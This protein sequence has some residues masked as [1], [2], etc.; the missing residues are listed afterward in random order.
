MSCEVSRRTLFKAGAAAMTVH[1]ALA[2]A[3]DVADPNV[4]HPIRDMYSTRSE[5]SK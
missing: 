1:S 2:R 3:A 4:Q 5:T